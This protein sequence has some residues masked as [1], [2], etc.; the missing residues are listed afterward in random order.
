MGNA[1][2]VVVR[3]LPIQVDVIFKAAQMRKVLPG[4]GSG[5]RGRFAT[6]FDQYLPDF[7][8]KRP[9]FFCSGLHVEHRNSLARP[10]M[11]RM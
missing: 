9:P 5:F 1:H 8:E 2:R 3:R 6:T 11:S 10:A 4:K 7:L